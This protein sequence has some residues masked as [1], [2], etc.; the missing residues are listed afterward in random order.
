MPGRV[1]TSCSGNP[2]G[3]CP[4]ATSGSRYSAID[5]IP[6]VVLYVLW[7]HVYLRYSWHSV[8]DYIS[9]RCAAVSGRV[10]NS[11]R[12][13]PSLVSTLP[14][15][16]MFLRHWRSPP[17]RISS[18]WLL[19]DHQFVPPNAPAPPTLPAAAA[20]FSVSRLTVRLFCQ[21]DSTCK[22]DP[23]AFV[24]LHLTCGPSV[25]TSRSIMLLHVVRFRSLSWQSNNT[26]SYQCT[27]FFIQLC[28]GGHFVVSLPWLLWTV[29]QWTWGAYI[30]SN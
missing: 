30:F 23:M 9:V 10:Y 15:P 16:C 27:S 29:L 2:N 25:V 17:H 24:Y 1:H 22:R 19:R 20:L 8:S 5:C 3:D 14:A 12:A 4:P 21:S 13:P 28:I 18:L 11:C 6:W 7:P 26:P